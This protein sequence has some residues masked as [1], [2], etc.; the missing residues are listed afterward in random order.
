VTASEAEEGQRL[1][2]SLVK[3][4]T[5]SDRLTARYLYSKSF[6]YTPEFK[7]WLAT[8]HK[9]AIYGT[10]EA[11]WRRIR[12]VPFTVTIP[13]DE[14]DCDLGSKLRA[15]LPGI[16]AWAVR[17]CLEWQRVGLSAP[18]EVK[19]ATQGYRA[20]MDKLGRFL[21]ECCVLDVQAQ[22]GASELYLAYSEWCEANGERAVSGTRFGRQ[23]AERGLTDK[24]RD[25]QGR[26]LYYG[27]GLL[28]HNERGAV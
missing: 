14:Q 16:L 7:I 10:D 11:I 18:E 5:G 2:E 23:L 9:P 24:G 6:E 13:P 28:T 22:A 21:D 3:Q 15:E 4:L 25:G 26:A 27:I 20:E 12:L 8:N 17:G 19:E 1:A